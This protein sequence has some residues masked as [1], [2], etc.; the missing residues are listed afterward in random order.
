MP[1]VYNETVD[2]H[3]TGKFLHIKGLSRDACILTYSTG[4][5]QEAPLEIGKG[6]VENLTI[7]AT[8]TS[9]DSG[10]K[11]HAYCV[12][13]DYST[14][15]NSSLQFRN[16]NFENDIR[17]CVGIGLRSNFTC[18]FIQCNFKSNAGS[19]P[20]YCHEQQADHITGQ[21][22][23]LIDCSFWQNSSSSFSNNAIRLQESSQYVDN[24][25]TIL[26]QRCIVYST[27]GFANGNPV[28]IYDYSG[29][30]ESKGGSGFLG[31]RVWPLDPM[32]ALNN[33]SALNARD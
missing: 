19:G 15:T 20:F 22:V 25:A 9:H 8:G 17:N 28:Y 4:D 30:K 2:V 31:S 12:H 14:S 16:C 21:R 13:I 26:I 7:K 10:A 27:I 33:N 5:Y 1:G 3:T 6:I 11:Q 32:S 18:S 24:Q 29:K 23:E